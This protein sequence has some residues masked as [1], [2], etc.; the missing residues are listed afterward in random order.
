MKYTYYLFFLLLVSS[1]NAQIGSENMTNQE[2]PNTTEYNK[3]TEAEKRIILQKGTEYPNTGEYN[4]HYEDGTYICRQ[5]NQQLYKSSSKFNS[6]C[7]WPSFDDE[8]DGAVNRILDSDGRR[9]EIVCSN[10][11]GH[12]GHVFIGE[13]FTAKNTRHCVNSISMKFVP[14]EQ[15]I[16]EIITSKEI[17]EL[18]TI[19]FGSGCFWCVEV[20]FQKLKGVSHV[21]S[22]YAGGKI[23]NPT[24]KMV[25]QGNTGSVEVAQ[26]VYD[27]KI[28]STETLIDIFF[29]VH[30]PTTLNRQGNDVG[31]Q[32]RSVIFYHSS[33][34]KEI[35]KNVLKRID[36]SKLWNEPIVTTIE[37]IYN[38]S[39]AEDYHQI[40]YNNNSS[41]NGYCNMVIRPKVKKFKIKYANLIK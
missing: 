26:L 33:Q 10:C 12:L 22:G 17:T 39:S 14:K 4:K 34:Q 11:K 7:G 27:P 37:S 35:A 20:L 6:N 41:N 32:Y 28:I 40:Y 9:T 18:D 38:Y 31:E 13:N 1:C 15:S 3:L 16:P 24:Y 30:D 19:T 25:C 8:L 2:K 29:H 5:C 23:K 21:E 36:S